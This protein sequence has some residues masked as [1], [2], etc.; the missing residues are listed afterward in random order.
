MIGKSP[1]V[2]GLWCNVFC[3]SLLLLFWSVNSAL[4]WSLW[5]GDEPPEQTGDMPVFLLNEVM[6]EGQVSSADFKGKVLLINFWATWCGPCVAEYPDLQKL[7]VDLKKKGFSVIGFSADKNHGAVRRFLEQ[8]GHTY[9]MAVMSG[10]SLMRDFKAGTGL[11]VTFLV[12]R[13][14]NIVEKYLGP[15]SYEKFR[16]EIEKVL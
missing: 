3:F 9:P 7:H 6:G 13:Q 14:G 12:N 4:A 2:V 11:P 15:R 10:G 1:R 8:N 16:S 5:G